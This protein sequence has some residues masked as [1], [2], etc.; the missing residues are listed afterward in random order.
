MKQRTG[1]ALPTVPTG[2]YDDEWEAARQLLLS[3]DKESSTR[4]CIRW[5]YPLKQMQDAGNFEW[6]GASFENI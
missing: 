1:N 4:M 3:N 6:G 2:K 5:L